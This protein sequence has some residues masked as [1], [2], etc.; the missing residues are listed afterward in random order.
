MVALGL[1]LLLAVAPNATNTALSCAVIDKIPAVAFAPP[2]PTLIVDSQVH[3][4]ATMIVTLDA[5]TALPTDVKLASSSGS[6][7]IDSA[8]MAQAEGTHFTPELRDCTPVSGEYLY[9]IE[10]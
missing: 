4:T 3:G 7:F 1:S 10:Y 8:A 2:T 6:R 5:L 9:T